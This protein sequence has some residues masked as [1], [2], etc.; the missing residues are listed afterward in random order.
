MA[1]THRTAGIGAGCGLA[2]LLALVLPAGAGDA[3]QP[4]SNQQAK[5]RHV[6]QDTDHMVRRVSAMLRVLDY[7]RM[8][9]SSEKRIL[10][11]VAATLSGLS[12]E[13][14]AE[15]IARLD[16]ALKASDDKRS[17]QEVDEAY[18]QHRVIL[19][20]LRALLLRYE[21]IKNLDQAAARLEKASKDQLELHLRG[22]QLFQEWFETAEWQMPNKRVRAEVMSDIRHEGD[23]QGDLRRDVVGVFGQLDRLKDRLP[24]EQKERLAKAEVY[25]GD[26]RLF[27]NLAR[28]SVHMHAQGAPNV[29]Q[30]S[31]TSAGTLQRKSAADLQELARILRTPQDRLAALQEARDRVVRAIQ[32]QDTLRQESSA[33]KDPRVQDMDTQRQQQG[34]VR[35]T[36]ELSDQQGRLG[37]TTHATQN[38]VKP[39]AP[40]VAAKIS[41]AQKAMEEAAQALRKNTPDAAVKPQHQAAEALRNVRKELDRMIAAAEKQQHDPLAALQKT[42]ETV[43]R[44]LKEQKD[45]RG[46]THEAEATRQPERLPH[47]TRKQEDLAKRTDDLNREPTAAKPEASDALDKAAKAMD[48]A[49]K[50][51]EDKKGSEA[52]TRQDKAIKALEEAKKSLDD[53]VAKVQKRRDDIAALENAGK[54]LA[55]LAKKESRVAD[56][57]RDLEH[58][59]GDQDKADHDAKELSRKQAELTPQA[60]DAGKQLE[61]AAPEAAKKVDEGAKHMDAAKGKIDN[62]ELSPAAKHA[63]QAANKLKEAEKAVAK[64]LNQKKGEEIAD[65]A[66]LEPKDVDPENAAQQ[67]AKAIERTKHAA[68]QSDKAAKAGPKAKGSQARKPSAEATRAMAKSQEAT[69]EAK[70]ALEQT[71]AQAPEQVQ[72]HLHEAGTDLNRAGQQLHQGEPAPANESQN[73]ALAHM[74]KALESLN[75]ALA[76][77]GRP[78]AHPG[79]KPSAL[80]RADQPGQKAGQKPGAEP[81]HKP[82]QSR[83]AKRGPSQELRGKGNGNRVANA[84]RRNSPSSLMDVIGEGSFMHL[85][86]RQ[87]E[88]IKQALSEKLPPEYAGLIQQYYVNI[89]RGRPAAPPTAPPKR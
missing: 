14:M 10:D 69:Q 7:Y 62:K 19:D 50:S 3:R 68:E 53:Q 47:M 48:N 41:P 23:E 16:K 79:Q 38:L 70:A 44:L 77:M 52:V 67:L 34:Q 78:G 65:Q 17:R 66:A 80:A 20:R 39:H 30:Q 28:V 49:A 40:E 29:L 6:R 72:P 54:R 2:I 37:H 5:Q 85:P 61:A 1:G 63:D 31:W 83:S 60:K 75:A 33:Q 11:E 27:K 22:G 81:G 55:E 73:Q 12:K 88:M 45:L 21:A 76:A 26:E 74:T 9:E 43:D 56:K 13:Q 64:A 35:Q 32:Q 36:Q 57:A 42:A 18:R 82:G 84:V 46:K 15:V 87:R 8:D 4:I 25:A 86:P 24:S 59:K 71:Q 58:K 51:L 89:A